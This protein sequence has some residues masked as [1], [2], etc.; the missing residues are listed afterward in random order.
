MNGN[1]KMKQQNI[2]NLNEGDL[3]K[4]ESRQSLC[5][6]YIVLKEKKI[7]KMAKSSKAGQKYSSQIWF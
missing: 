6:G 7:L 5:S 4:G 3:L 2:Y 1:V